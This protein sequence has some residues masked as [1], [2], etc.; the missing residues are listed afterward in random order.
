MKRR[1]GSHLPG[2]LAGARDATRE[3]CFVEIHLAITETNA[4]WLDRIS[5]SRANSGFLQN[6]SFPSAE[7]RLFRSLSVV[8]ST[9]LFFVRA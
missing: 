1:P 4:F 2:I 3:E 9:K 7:T 6:L 5:G 8:N